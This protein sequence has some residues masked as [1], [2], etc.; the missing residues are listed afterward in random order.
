M[1]ADPESNYNPISLALHGLF[2]REHN[3]IADQLQSQNPA[4]SDETLYQEARYGRHLLFDIH[5]IQNV[6]VFRNPWHIDGSQ[7]ATLAYSKRVVAELQSITWQQFAPPVSGP[8]RAVSNYSATTDPCIDAF[9]ATV[10]MPAFIL[11]T[12]LVRFNIS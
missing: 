3:Y 6:P 9:F 1:S 8:M 10:A 11:A 12:T 2:I 4:W 7:P 5:Q